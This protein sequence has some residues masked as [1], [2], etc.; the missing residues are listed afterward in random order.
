MSVVRL[1]LLLLSAGDNSR[2]G[3]LLLFLVL[4]WVWVC[5]EWVWW[6]VGVGVDAFWRA[7]WYVCGVVRECD[8]SCINV[9]CLERVSA[10]HCC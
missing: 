7:V 1:V 3:Q 9:W 6:E 10:L 8:V 2:V 4:V 5:T